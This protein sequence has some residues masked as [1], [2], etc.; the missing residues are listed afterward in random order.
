MSFTQFAM[1]WQSSIWAVQTDCNFDY[2]RTVRALKRLENERKNSLLSFEA[3]R[4]SPG[5][6]SALSQRRGRSSSFLK[7]ELSYNTRL[8]VAL[9]SSFAM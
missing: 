2:F 8:D 3:G 6:S 1:L 9:L 5:F 7:S 4:P